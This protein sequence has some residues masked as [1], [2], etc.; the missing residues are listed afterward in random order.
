VYSSNNINPVFPIVLVPLVLLLS[1]CYESSEYGKSSDY[2]KLGAAC[3]T[4]EDVTAPTVYSESPADNS[5]YNSPATT[6]AVTFSEKMATGS[7]TTNTSDTTCSGSFQL[8]SDNFT[9]CIKMSAAPVASDNDTIF[10]I[11]P[12]S[13]LSAATT[14]K[15]K[16]TTSVTD[17]PC[18]TLGSDNSSIVGF[19]TSPSGSGTI[20]GSV[21]K[22]D[23]SPLG[24]VSLI[25]DQWGSTVATTTSDSNG[26]FSQTPL[27]LGRHTVTY[28]MDGYLDLVVEEL[29]ETDGQ[30]I[31]LETARLLPDNCTS[32]T[33]SGNI[34]NALTG[35]NM[36]GV[37]L[38]VTPGIN[39]IYGRHF[40]FRGTAFG[41]TDSNGAWSLSKDP[42]WYTIMSHISGYYYGYINVFAC[43]NQANQNN[44]LRETLN[45][46]EMS[47]LLTWP[48][49]NP[50]TGVD[51]DSHLYIP[52][53]DIGATRNSDCDGNADDGDK[54]HLYYRTLQS[55]PAVYNGVS[56]DNYHIYGAGDNVTL[57]RDLR[58]SPGDE[59]TTISNV[60]S[61]TYSF[62]VHNHAD[63]A[64]TASDN[65]SKSRAKV[66]V[67]YNKGGTL[68]EKTFHPPN[69]NGT[70]WRVFTFNSSDSGSGFTRVRTM[71][72]EDTAADVY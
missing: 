30:T 31:Q 36:S 64:A 39:R 60:G 13:S 67:W 29:L 15:V 7:V 10:T 48:K 17:I 23:G 21:Q 71:T 11:T 1:S 42:G 66:R 62:S 16:I 52:I 4:T 28:S 44:S 18:N 72:N 14:F 55:N 25:D 56:T 47:I 5:T 33:M 34:T 24:G 58:T 26:D 63:K 65:L 40:L 59:S 27:S 2:E 68:I 12:A 38:H 53:I 22:G 45:E 54:C 57:D 32:G 41:Y 50:V 6:V 46:G 61:G 49:T 70:L 20:L 51:L 69:A 9:T 3:I 37:H 35:D 43:G 8:S 19:S